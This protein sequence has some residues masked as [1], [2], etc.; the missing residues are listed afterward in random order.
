MGIK[1][2]TN[3]ALSSCQ[4]AS[5]SVSKSMSKNLV[6]QGTSSIMAKNTSPCLPPQPS[7]VKPADVKK[8]KKAT[9][10]HEDIH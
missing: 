4:Q 10:R 2:L 7:N 6:S 5:F 3:S 8:V 1:L 9:S